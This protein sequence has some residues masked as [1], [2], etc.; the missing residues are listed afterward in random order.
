MAAL[1]VI[2]SGMQVALMAPTE[3][4]AEQHYQNMSLWCGDLGVQVELLL[5]KTG[6]K[7]RDGLLDRLEVG[8]TDLLIGTHA[9]FQKGV[10]Y[11]NLGPHAG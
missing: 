11:H 4:L 8:T 1:Q 7:A 3:L 2:E 10:D 5:G 6:K 9:L